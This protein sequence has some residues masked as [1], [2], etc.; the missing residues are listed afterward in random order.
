MI[1]PMLRVEF[2]G[3]LTGLARLLD[4]IQEQGSLHITEIPLADG[5]GQTSL[6]RVKLD[7][8]QRRERDTVT[9]LSELLTESVKLLP[10]RLR[11]GI[12]AGPAYRSF[13]ES[14]K[15]AETSA[16]SVA[17]RSMHAT[18]RSLTRRQNNLE[19]DIQAIEIYESAVEAL[20][21]L[22]HGLRLDGG[23]EL[24]GLIL[25]PRS[26]RARAAMRASLERLTEGEGRYAE[27]TLADRRVAVALGFKPQ[28]APAVNALILGSSVS[29]MAVPRYLRDKP[30]QEAILRMQEDIASLRSKRAAIAEQVKAFQERKGAELLALCAVCHDRHARYAAMHAMATT[31][32]GFI[33]RGWAPEHSLDGLRAAAEAATGGVAVVRCLSQGGL[34]DP[35]VLL[36]NNRAVRQFEPL[37]KL[38]P[39]PRY[40]TIDPTF[41]L[42]TVFPPVFGLMLA[43]IGYGLLVGAGALIMRRVMRH[44]EIGRKLAFVAG[45]CA[46]F[47]ILFGAVFGEFFGE[48]GKQLF[49]LEPLWQERFSFHGADRVRTLVGY[50]AITLGIGF[51]HVLLALVLS[52][53]NSRRT[54]DHNKAVESLA[55]IAGVFAMLFAVGRMTNFLPPA[56]LTPLVASL[57]AF[58]ALMVHQVAHRPSHG[59]LL[60]LEVLGTIGNILSYVRIMAVGLVSVVLAFLANLFG[61]MIGN[62]VLAVIVSLLVHALNL[63]L[64]IIDPTIQGLRLHYVEFSSKFFLGGGSPYAPFRKSGGNP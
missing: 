14:W 61:E 11:D 9:E 3:P 40:R 2:V 35:P 13:L 49:G 7:E 45:I 15:T 46:I 17:A 22:I 42:A 16:V 55:K 59:L 50:M 27:A 44:K 19:D 23:W 33:L 20:A 38:F 60:P 62:V 24:A 34:E 10:E 26:R 56:F 31:Q 51:V 41:F 53:I 30:F 28:H 12:V 5:T 58:L 37:L 52:V 18:V 54:G 47:T 4:A 29:R 21:P 36:D 57:V 1:S 39:L 6:H 63:A 25:E 8:T 64:G 32:H 43:D 48:A